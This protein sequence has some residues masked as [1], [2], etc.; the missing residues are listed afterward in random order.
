ML[1]PGP[2]D[3]AAGAS[4]AARPPRGAGK[5]PRASARHSP[6]GLRGASRGASR[7]LRGRKRGRPPQKVRERLLR[8]RVGEAPLLSGEAEVG[9]PFGSAWGAWCGCLALAG[10]RSGPAGR[11][12]QRVA[13]PRLSRRPARRAE[14]RGGSLAAP[15]PPSA[16]GCSPWAEESRWLL[17]PPSATTSPRRALPCGSLFL[18]SVS[19]EKKFDPPGCARSSSKLLT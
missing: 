15:L 6:L 10:R 8:V 17:S 7:L 14:G 11:G 16:S 18:A 3:G 4:L 2:S 9:R 13:G 1:S 5:R 12:S 19:S